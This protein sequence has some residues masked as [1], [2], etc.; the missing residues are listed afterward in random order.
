MAKAHIT[1]K[2][3]DEAD[4]IR[5]VEAPGY[6][7]LITFAGKVR[8][9]ARGKCVVAIEYTAYT[10]LAQSELTRIAREA[11]QRTIC[12][13]AIAHRL[14]PIPIGET[15]VFVAVASPHR[16]EAFETCRWVIDTIKTTVPLWKRET[17]DDNEVWIEGEQ[18][19]LAKASV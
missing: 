5:A 9:Y 4:L 6:G 12:A 15:S 1:D 8:N 19:F 2:P 3:I 18:A 17:Y 10:P 16:S 14:G 13:C 7:A 11:E